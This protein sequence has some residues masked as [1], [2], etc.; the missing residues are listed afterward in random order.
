[1]TVAVA[2]TA[3]VLLTLD[4]S[5]TQTLTMQ[6]TNLDALQTLACTV[7]RK[8]IGGMDWA[9]TPLIA[10]ESIA[11]LATAIADLDCGGSLEVRITGIASGAGLD[12]SVGARDKPRRP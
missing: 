3:T 5:A 7:Q 6:V 10:L 12:A 9:D 11:P 8:A 1:M 4:T 2:P